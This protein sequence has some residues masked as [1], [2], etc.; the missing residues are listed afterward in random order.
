MSRAYVVKHVRNSCCGTWSGPLA[1]DRIRA[2]IVGCVQGPCW[3][4]SLGPMLGRPFK[5]HDVGHLRNLRCGTYSRPISQRV[6]CLAHPV[7]IYC[8][9]EDAPSCVKSV[10]KNRECS[11]RSKMRTCFI[12][13][14]PGCVFNANIAGRVVGLCCKTC[15][16]PIL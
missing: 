9:E 14:V 16:G 1:W 13:S 4:T 5:T 12:Q 7:R 15:S 11:G 2:Y 8:M 6:C 10:N 3:G